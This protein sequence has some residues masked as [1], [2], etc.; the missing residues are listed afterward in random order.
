MM[1]GAGERA[2]DRPLAGTRFRAARAIGAGSTSEV[3]EAR[4]PLGEVRAV[5]VL[6]GTIARSSDAALRLM[7]EGRA[8]AALDH[9]NLVKVSEVGST[10]D[11]RPYFVMER[12]EGETLRDRIERVGRLPLAEACARMVEALAGLAAA[13]RAGVVHRDV[14][15]S[16]IFLT[17]DVGAHFAPRGERAVLLDFG[18]A[19]I[20]GDLSGLTTDAHVL[21]TP[22]YL[23][24]EQ[25]LGGKVDARTDIYS[26]GLVLFEAITGRGPYDATDTIPIMRAHLSEEPHSLR[27]F[28]DAPP[29]LERAITR[30][31]QKEPGR[32][33]PSAEALAVVLRAWSQA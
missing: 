15:P 1:V 16:N 26:V 2:L 13:H 5:K 33:W 9:P 14:K 3:F 18:I 32:R 23:A 4:D 27:R 19:K 31:L 28:V 8:L 10:A 25:I 17:R 6:R 20:D 12:L 24:P 11:G 22:R 30:A 29:D 7:Q 21:G